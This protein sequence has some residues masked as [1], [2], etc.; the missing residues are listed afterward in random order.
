M[1]QEKV[2]KI[3]LI[4]GCIA[5]VLIIALGIALILSCLDIYN[6]GPHPYSAEAIGQRF[7]RVAILV[8]ICIALVL[9]GI[10]LSLVL[11]LDEKRPKASRDMMVTMKKL[12]EKVPAMDAESAGKAHK[13]QMH[14]MVLR[15]ATAVLFA[16]LMVYPAIYFMN[17]S[18]FTIVSVNDDIRTAVCIALIPATVGLLLCFGCSLLE[19][20]SIERETDIYKKSIAAAK[21]I[22]PLTAP[23]IEPK[24]NVTVLVTRCV[25]LAVAVC[26][27]V[28][29]VI[30]GGM[31]DVL[32]KAVAICT[33]CIGLG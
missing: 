32:D 23:V 13:E 15:I 24:K 5:A 10:V 9:G 22:A 30:N 4:Y 18:H 8:Y 21:G 11:P 26:F 6:S 28:L 7:Q 31:K 27:I 20:K 19:N 1:T 2:K 12:K 29:G 16:A 33:E 3:H 14:R 25:I 17:G